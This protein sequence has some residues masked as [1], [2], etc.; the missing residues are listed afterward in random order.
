[1]SQGTLVWNHLFVNIIVNTVEAYVSR[2]L[3]DGKMVSITGAGHLQKWFL[4][5]SIKGV[6][7]RWLLTGVDQLIINT[8]NA[9][10]TIT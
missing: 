8:M 7:H 4:Y 5:V 6:R 1:M 2:H 10:N 9:K 3:W